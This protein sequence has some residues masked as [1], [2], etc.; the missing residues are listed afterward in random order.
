MFAAAVCF[1]VRVEFSGLGTVTR[2]VTTFLLIGKVQGS[3]QGTGQEGI[4]FVGLRRTRSTGLGPGS[5]WPPW[6]REAGQ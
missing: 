5:R 6:T 4:S 1:V 2:P 3:V